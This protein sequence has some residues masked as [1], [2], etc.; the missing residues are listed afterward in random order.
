MGSSGRSVPVT[1]LP[2]SL[3]NSSIA[4][5]PP[6][7]CLAIV[8]AVA[9]RAGDGDLVG[10]ANP[11]SVRARMLRSLSVA[12]WF[13]MDVEASEMAGYDFFGGGS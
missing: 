5:A 1:E 9:D 11:H 4:V 7:L 6:G 8:H 12:V 2:R 13:S 3:A 10:R